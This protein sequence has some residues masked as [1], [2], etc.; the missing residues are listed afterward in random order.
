MDS[1]ISLKN[2]YI[3][4]KDNL[5]LSDVN[6]EIK[7]G[8]FVFLIGKTGSGKSSLLKTLYADLFLE[9]GQ[10]V[11]A[12]YELEKIKYKEIPFLRRKIGII[13]QDFQLLPDRNIQQNLRFFME[14]MGWEEKAKINERI[15]E[16][17][18]MVGLPEVLNKMPHQ[19]SGGEQQRIAIA[20]ALLNH[21]AILLA[22]EP[23]GNLDPEKSVEILKL[24]MKINQVS[25]TAVLMATH[26][27]DLIERFPKRTL[28]CDGGQIKDLSDN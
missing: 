27:L 26:E 5:I 18:E 9:K 25:K 19:L 16:V 1:V 23:T 13:F 2:A 3:F 20:R 7:Q 11:V 10:G 21:P 24:F 14:A 12:G 8:E 17:L 15:V 22:D 28:F 4:Q 6:F